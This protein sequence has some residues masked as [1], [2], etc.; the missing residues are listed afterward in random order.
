MKRCEISSGDAVAGLQ[1]QPVVGLEVLK[2]KTVNQKKID[3]QPN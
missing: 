1:L 2:G 3:V